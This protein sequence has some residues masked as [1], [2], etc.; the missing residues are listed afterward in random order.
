MIE[1]IYEN[2]KIPLHYSNT[3]SECH[4]NDLEIRKMAFKSLDEKLFKILGEYIG[5]PIKPTQKTKLKKE[6]YKDIY[7]KWKKTS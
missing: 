7:Y 2:Q 5:S 1:F 3:R 6:K 4:G